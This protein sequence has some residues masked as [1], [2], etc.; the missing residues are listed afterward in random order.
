MQVPA[1]QVR[2]ACLNYPR[3][4]QFGFYYQNNGFLTQN[5]EDMLV[6]GIQA[7]EISKMLNP[8]AFK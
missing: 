8:K 4:S 7:G 2:P 6:P 1:L 3:R 5:T